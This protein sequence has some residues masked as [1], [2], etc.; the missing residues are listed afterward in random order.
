M[1]ISNP[2]FTQG[3]VLNADDLDAAFLLLTN[4]INRLAGLPHPESSG[5]KNLIING[6]FSVWQRGVSQTSSGYGSVDRWTNENVGST[7]TTSQQTFT[8][9]QTDVPNNPRHYIRT[10]V[11]SVAG[12]SNYAAMSQHIEDVT[13]LA[14]QE[15]TLSFWAKADSVKNIAIEF[16]QEF[17]TGGSPST[18][19]T[20]IEPTL[21]ALTT[22]WAQYTLTVTLPSISGKTL[23]TDGAHTSSTYVNIWMDAGTS[24]DGRTN[25]LGQQSGTFDIS[26]IQLEFGDEATAFEYIS[27]GSQLAACQRYFERFGGTAIYFDIGTGH[28]FDT[29]NVYSVLNYQTTKRVNPNITTSSTTGIT[30]FSNGATNASTAISAQVITVQTASIKVTTTT[31]TLGQSSIVRLNPSEYIDVSAEL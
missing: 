15:V 5:N 13:R 10:A 20:T 9:G 11:T 31:V 21:V 24:F 29:T 19:V 17:G 25:S 7:K 27:A 8:L 26:N 22:G 28:Y 23:G 30:A 3:A 16:T 12:A 1:T 14:G 4:E 18:V 6:D 2:T